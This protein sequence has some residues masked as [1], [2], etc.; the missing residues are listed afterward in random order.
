MASIT[1]LVSA[2]PNRAV[3]IHVLALYRSL[4]VA[5]RAAPSELVR[6]TLL[7]AVFGAGPG[8]LLV[9]SK[10][11]IDEPTAALDAKTEHEIFV[12]HNLALASSADRIMV[13]QEAR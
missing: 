8:A 2:V 4:L 3:D 13:P 9:L 6:L 5:W 11:V 12:S 10:V 1:V 7:N